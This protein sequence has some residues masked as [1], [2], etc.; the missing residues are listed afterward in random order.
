ME[1][2]GQ[3][4][5]TTQDSARF[6]RKQKTHWVD[7]PKPLMCIQLPWFVKELTRGMELWKLRPAI[8]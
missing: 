3:G 5:E 8:D 4:K 1:Y 7:E 6:V 2:Q